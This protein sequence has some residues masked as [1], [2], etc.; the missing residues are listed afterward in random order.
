MNR[1][2]SDISKLP[3]R[4]PALLLLVTITTAVS[5]ISK[6]PMRYPLLP[7][8]LVNL[9]TVKYNRGRVVN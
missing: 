4:Y 8:P 6:L 9:T 2:V 1:P 7:P 5:D 3:M